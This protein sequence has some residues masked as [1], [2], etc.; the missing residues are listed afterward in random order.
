[1]KEPTSEQW[2]TEVPGKHPGE[3]EVAAYVSSRAADTL[4]H[5]IDL[6]E[7]IRSVAKKFG[8]AIG[9]HGSLARDIDLIAAPWTEQA[10]EPELLAAA[11]ANLARAFNENGWAKVFGPGD[12]DDKL[13]PHGRMCWSI[14]LDGGAYI[15]LSVM[16][17]LAAREPT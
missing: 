10:V 1:M 11:I 5:Y 15:D 14:H 3:K 4:R 8:Y 16:P 9:V 17:R 12:A 6:I 7:P 13:K 2:Q